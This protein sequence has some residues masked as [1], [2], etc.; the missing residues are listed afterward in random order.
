MSTVSSVV[1][2]VEDFRSQLTRPR[3]PLIFTPEGLQG[4]IVESPQGASAKTC[5][6]ALDELIA[7]GC[8]S[9]YKYLMAQA[10]GTFLYVLLRSIGSGSSAPGQ[11]EG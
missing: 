4:A 3:W 5:E 7:S 1:S 2:P 10:N 11:D 9:N 6:Q 8:V